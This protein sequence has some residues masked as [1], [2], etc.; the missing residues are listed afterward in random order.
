MTVTDVFVALLVA[1]LLLVLAKLIRGAV[2][3]FRSL[4]LP[5]SVIAGVIALLIGPQVSGSLLAAIGVPAAA[6]GAL[7]EAV[8]DVWEGL[9]SLL[10]SVVFAAL[11]IGKTIPSLREIWRIAGPQVALGQ[12]IAWGQYV[13]GILLVLVLLTPVFGLDP[14][15]GALIE[16]GF[17]GGHGTAAGLADTFA[18]FGFAAGADLALGLATVGLVAGVLIGTVL[19]NWGIRTGRMTLSEAGD[20]VES[21]RA[22]TD[23]DLDDVDDRERVTRQEGQATDPLS[24]HVGYV[25]I[26]ISLG[27]LLQQALSAFERATWGRDGGVELLVHMPLFPLAMLGG[28]ALQVVLDRTGRAALVD[29]KLINRLGGF[30]LDLIIVAALGTL[31]LGALGGNLG[32]FVLLAL[33]G[34]VWNVAAYL[35]L[36]PRIIPEY[37]YERGLGDFGQS[38]G[39]TVTGLLLMRIADPQNR[40]GGLEAFGYKQLLF[41]PVVGGG[42]FTAASI[43]L[44]AQFGPVP[45]LVFTG[46]LM[47]FWIVFGVRTFGPAR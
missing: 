25:A 5:A 15:A 36:A 9:P 21:A 19:V 34:I 14:I 26:A 37:A 29:R 45:V 32:P 42:L 17:E 35:L 44:I 13:V 3:L 16:I 11:F 10:I 12:A 23:D 24:I 18:T 2:P 47:L 7:P 38:M 46:V 30:A 1:G 6:G 43:P 40:S 28:V 22:E 27:W 33:A 8:L 20:P 4:F 39:M 31:S 41:E